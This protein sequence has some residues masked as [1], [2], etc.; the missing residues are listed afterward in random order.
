MT[1]SCVI[2]DDEL[3]AIRI[4]ERF[5]DQTPW[6][7]LLGSFSVPEEALSFL[8][9]QEVDLLLLDIQMPG[10]TGLELLE[11]LQQNQLIIFTTAF[12][13]YALQGFEWA[14][15]DYLLKPIAYDRFLRAATRALKLQGK[16]AEDGHLSL[17]ADRRLYRVPKE[18]ILYIQAYGDYLKIQTEDRLYN[19]KMALQALEQKLG[20]NRFLRVHRSWLVNLKKVTYMEGNHLLIGDQK[21]PVS[22]SYKEKVLDR[23][24]AK[25]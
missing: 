21:V 16:V 14:A 4:M 15:V 8:K 17:R 9:E 3:P 20:D 6:L 1:L 7:D 18:E 5:V 25:D 22:E 13:D 19:P 10:M 23:L 24:D 12:A 2:V 11:K